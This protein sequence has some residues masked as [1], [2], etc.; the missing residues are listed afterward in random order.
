MY[1]VKSCIIETNLA[2][3]NSSL[4]GGLDVNWVQMLYK[5]STWA[6]LLYFIY[7]YV[8]MHAVPQ[9]IHISVKHSRLQPDQKSMQPYTPP[10]QCGS[11][12]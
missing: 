4:L 11:G 5:L 9:L 6:T 10:H 1:D 7:R 3:P 12:R 8:Y 2:L